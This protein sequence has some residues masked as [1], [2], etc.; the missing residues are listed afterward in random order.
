MTASQPDIPTIEQ[1]R[2]FYAEEIAA[3]ANLDQ[4]RLVEAFAR[5][6]RERFLGPA[7]WQVGGPMFLQNAFRT[8]SEPRD[9][10]HNVAVA[11]K[12][13]QSLNNGQPGLLAGWIAALDLAEGHRVFHLGAGTGY[14]TAILAEVVG[15]SGTVV[16]AEVEP[17]LA[18]M[19]SENLRAY[20][21]VT[22]H[23]ADGA[24]V[25]P[26]RCEAILI[27][28]GVTHPHLPW[29]HGLNHRARM[30]LP[31]TTRMPQ[32]WGKGLA[33]RI[34]R[35]Q[36]R[37]AAE[38]LSMV[39]IYSCTS[40]RDAA[41]EPLLEKAM[42]SQQFMKLKSVRLDAHEQTDSCIVH[43]AKVCLSAAALE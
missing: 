6:S 8:T 34:T 4:P 23:C 19:A 20:P 16:A 18:A 37:F 11:L 12:M 38:I 15:P 21:N 30:V 26:G 41:L 14:F 39:A 24:A 25:D 28:A 43:G 31:L 5:V 36:D 2:R 22:V 33:I 3:S 27:N 1:Y 17:D 32:G 13:S 10:Y 35:N 40:V 9:V 29:L 42:T 7:P